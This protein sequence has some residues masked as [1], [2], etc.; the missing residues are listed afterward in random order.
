LPREAHG[1]G[2]GD[3]KQQIKSMTEQPVRMVVKYDQ[4]LRVGNRI[5]V[6]SKFPASDHDESFVMKPYETNLRAT[7]PVTNNLE[8]IAH[9]K[10]SA[11][12][13]AQH[14]KAMFGSLHIAYGYGFRRRDD[15]KGTDQHGDE[16]P[17]PEMLCQRDLHGE[18]SSLICDSSSHPAFKS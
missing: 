2:S 8:K 5:L 10:Y 13:C 1:G 4:Y 11:L 9:R 16:C 7:T 12:F 6:M 18:F 3:T 15:L 17:V 14:K